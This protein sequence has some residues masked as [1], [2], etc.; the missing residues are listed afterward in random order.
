VSLDLK[1]FSRNF[2]RTLTMLSPCVES[3]GQFPLRRDEWLPT[4]TP[5]N[6][7]EQLYNPIVKALDDAISNMTAGED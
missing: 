6:P 2:P 5:P 3:Y 7:Q 1:N 4:R